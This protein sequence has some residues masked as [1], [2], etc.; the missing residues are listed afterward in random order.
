MTEVA[1]LARRSFSAERRQRPRT[2]LHDLVNYLEGA[3]YVGNHRDT[4][5]YV[6]PLSTRV[7]EVGVPYNRI[8]YELGVYWYGTDGPKLPPNFVAFRFG[9][10]LQS[11][12][13][14]ERSEHFASN[15]DVY[16]KATLTWGPGVLLHLGPA[17]EPK[18][19]VKSGPIR[20]TK[21]WAD[22]DLLLTSPTVQEAAA[23]T[24]ERDR[25]ERAT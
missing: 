8:P 7:S 21:V 10:R 11:I 2:F 18:V 23:L 25:R 3:G 12:H 17:I 9:G 24:R 14:V 16:P 22:I 15:R 20:D 4:R 13:H 6:V 1:L 5:A 19:D